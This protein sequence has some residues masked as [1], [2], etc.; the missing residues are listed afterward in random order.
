MT[1]I[2]EMRRTYRFFLFIPRYYQESIGTFNFK[3]L[4]LISYNVLFAHLLHYARSP[5]HVTTVVSVCA[6]Y[7]QWGETQHTCRRSGS[8]RFG[9]SQVRRSYSGGYS[10]RF[11]SW[12]QGIM[13]RDLIQCMVVQGNKIVYWW[14]DQGHCVVVFNEL[15]RERK[16]PSLNI[17]YW[18]Q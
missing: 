14:Y 3:R 10:C 11:R 13:F 4:M 8:W 2:S 7:S 15:L 18:K 1:R 5:S 9:R 17:A 12:I 16:S 6:C